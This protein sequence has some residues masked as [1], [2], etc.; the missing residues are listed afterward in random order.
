MIYIESY[1]LLYTFGAIISRCSFAGRAAQ[2]EYEASV[3]GGTNGSLTLPWVR[4]SLLRAIISPSNPNA[5]PSTSPNTS[6]KT[7]SDTSPYR[8]RIGTLA[9]FP[10]QSLTRPLTRALTQT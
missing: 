1:S 2:V 7:S 10:T 6:P 5:V 4:S 8:D 3:G 9:R